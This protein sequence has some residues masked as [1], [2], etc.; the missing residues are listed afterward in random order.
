MRSEKYAALTACDFL[1]VRPRR[2]RENEFIWV[3]PVESINYFR[4]ELS[5]PLAAYLFDC[6]VNR[7]GLLVGT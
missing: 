4:V 6:I 1:E 7:P 2:K 5:G 3:E